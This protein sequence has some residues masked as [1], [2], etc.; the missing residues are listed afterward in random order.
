MRNIVAAVMAAVMATGTAHADPTPPPSPGYQIP[1]PGRAAVPGRAGLSAVVSSDDAWP[2]DS[3]T[4]PA[5]GRGTQVIQAASKQSFGPPLPLSGAARAEETGH[6]GIFFFG[7]GSSLGLTARAR[8][9]NDVRT[10]DTG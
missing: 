2:A 10:P 4:T 6:L 9:L 5:R 3:G 7:A 8:T 1:G